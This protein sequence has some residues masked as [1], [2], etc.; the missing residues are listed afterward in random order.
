MFVPA[1]SVYYLLL[2]NS[3]LHEQLLAMRVVPTSPNAFYAYLR[4]MSYAF[5]GRKLQHEAR[6]VLALIEQI[7]KDFSV[8]SEDFRVL[9]KHLSNAKS[10]W[11]EAAQE[12][13]RFSER[14]T[15]VRRIEVDGKPAEAPTILRLTGD[16][17]A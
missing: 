5:R 17:S 12:M 7:A 4:A 13:D 3:Q 10:K 14:I 1:E 15:G 6:H 9:G 16:G 11:D 2:R 8:F